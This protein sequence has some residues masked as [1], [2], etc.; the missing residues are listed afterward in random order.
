MELV[1]SH[2]DHSLVVGTTHRPDE[3]L[4][5]K[6]ATIIQ[7]NYVSWKGRF[8]IIVSIDGF[9]LFD[10]VSFARCGWR[11]RT[12]T[13]RGVHFQSRPRPTDTINRPSRKHE[14]P[15]PARVGAGGW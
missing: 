2:W 11:N 5:D 12:K 13:A 10:C 9:P 14:S 6:R 4:T 7:S 3:L 15:D 1:S 8:D